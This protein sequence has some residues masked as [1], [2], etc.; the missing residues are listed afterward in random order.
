[1]TTSATASAVPSPVLRPNSGVHVDNGRIQTFPN[2]TQNEEE[3]S[4]ATAV[5]AT[6]PVDASLAS[7]EGRVP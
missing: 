5:P 1:M 3:G 2:Q 6:T 7:Q 4:F